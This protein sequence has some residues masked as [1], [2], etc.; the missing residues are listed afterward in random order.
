MLRQ[1]VEKVAVAASTETTE[2]KEAIVVEDQ[3]VA[4]EE[5]VA[6]AVTQ[7]TAAAS[8]H[9]AEEISQEELTAVAVAQIV[10]AETQVPADKNLKPYQ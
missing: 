6:I 3:G 7:E 1:E 5:K 9:V 8:K 10:V 4:V 2:A